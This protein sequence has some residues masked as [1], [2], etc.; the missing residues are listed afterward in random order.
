MSEYKMRNLGDGTPVKVKVCS[1][2][3]VAPAN[4]DDCGRFGD[5]ECP[6]FGVGLEAYNKQESRPNPDLQYFKNTK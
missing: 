6:Y 1:R 3:G 5:P 4:V 2:C